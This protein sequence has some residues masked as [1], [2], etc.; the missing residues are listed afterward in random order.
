M[1]IIISQVLFYLGK[2]FIFTSSY[3]ENRTQKRIN[4]RIYPFN[5]IYYFLLTTFEISPRISGIRESIRTGIH[6]HVKD[7]T[8]KS[9]LRTGI[10]ITT[11]KRAKDRMVALISC[12]FEANPNSFR[13][14]LSDL[15]EKALRSSLVISVANTIVCAPSIELGKI[16]LSPTT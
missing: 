1:T 6:S 14:N 3:L 16:H 13:V 10:Y 15:T 2:V 7:T 11:S 8:S 9:S 4:H 12:G 5:S